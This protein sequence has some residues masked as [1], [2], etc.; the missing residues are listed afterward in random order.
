M[1]LGAKGSVRDRLTP[2]GRVEGFRPRELYSTAA[3][4]RWGAKGAIIYAAFGGENHTTALRARKC[5]PP[6]PLRGK[7]GGAATRGGE[8]SEPVSRMFFMLYDS[9]SQSR[10]ASCVPF[11][12]RGPRSGEGMYEGKNDYD[13]LIL[14]LI[15]LRSGGRRLAVRTAMEHPIGALPRTPFASSRRSPQGETRK[16][17]ALDIVSHMTQTANPVTLTSYSSPERAIPQPSA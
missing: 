6:C 9:K 5:N 3:L 14:C 12:G 15:A 10:N 4:A 1:A 8:R 2:P 16:Y 13:T 17:V 7:G 11:R